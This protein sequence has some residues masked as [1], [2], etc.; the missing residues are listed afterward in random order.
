[1]YKENPRG[2]LFFSV[3]NDKEKAKGID[4]IKSGC[5]VV[6]FISFGYDY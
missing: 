3:V 2:K 4:R 6:F 1:M 5:I